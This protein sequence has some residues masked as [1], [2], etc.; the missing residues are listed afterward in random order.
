[1]KTDHFFFLFYNIILF[2]TIP[3]FASYGIFGMVVNKIIL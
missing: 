3:G 2:T 1:M